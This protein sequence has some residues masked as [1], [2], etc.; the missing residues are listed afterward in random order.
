M[1][2]KLFICGALKLLFFLLDLRCLES[3]A[4]GVSWIPNPLS[5]FWVY[6]L[7]LY[8]IHIVADIDL[9]GGGGWGQKELI[10]C[11]CCSETFFPFL[12]CNFLSFPQLVSLG[13][14]MFR[15]IG[16][17]LSSWLPHSIPKI[18]PT[19]MDRTFYASENVHSAFRMAA[20]VPSVTGE[21]NPWFH[22]SL[23]NVKIAA[24]LGVKA[25]V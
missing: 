11:S 1:S 9:E 6:L 19:V 13:L 5:A 24:C 20:E 2:L 10:Y 12:F 23:V 15:Y 17:P 14:P 22:L 25:Q 4:W 7:S 16:L 18:R 21:W 8:N 3:L